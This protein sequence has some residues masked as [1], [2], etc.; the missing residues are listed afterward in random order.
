MLLCVP[1]VI[2]AGCQQSHRSS[3][4]QS[5]DSNYIKTNKIN[6][7]RNCSRFNARTADFSLLGLHARELIK[8]NDPRIQRC[9][10][11]GPATFRLVDGRVCSLRATNFLGYKIS[12]AWIAL[13]RQ[14]R[15]V[16]FW[17]ETGVNSFGGVERS[18]W[19]QYCTPN[20]G[21]SVAPA[22]TVD[23]WRLK[24]GGL[25]VGSEHF[26]EGPEAKDRRFENKA[27][28]HFI[29]DD[30]EPGPIMN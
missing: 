28:V 17:I 21:H 13:D 19:K 20:V 23:F 2:F 26:I 24:D 11:G 10:S 1:F 3:S 30:Y 14:R 4:A 29:Y 22:S 18:M 15:L 25:Y 7:E 5:N 8:D 12:K 6:N 9:V 16:E 27:L